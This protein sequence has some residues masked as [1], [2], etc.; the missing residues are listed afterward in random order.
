[1]EINI[2]IN[3]SET[4]INKSKRTLPR[5]KT[6]DY[7]EEVQLCGNILQYIHI[8]KDGRLVAIEL[9]IVQDYK[10]D[11]LEGLNIIINYNYLI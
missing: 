9:D 5:L 8:E 6:V 3:N 4:G 11:D 7:G 1:M 10:K 2:N